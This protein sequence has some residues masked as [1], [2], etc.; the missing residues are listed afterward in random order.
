MYNAFF[1]CFKPSAPGEIEPHV[2]HPRVVRFMLANKSAFLEWL[3]CSTAAVH[4]TCDKAIGDSHMRW[5]ELGTTPHNQPSAL[6]THRRVP[7]SHG[8]V[9]GVSNPPAYSM[10][11]GRRF[12]ACL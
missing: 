6:K 10:L 9:I 7:L 12:I 1:R 4:P 5:L 3:I 11:L 2:A 8:A